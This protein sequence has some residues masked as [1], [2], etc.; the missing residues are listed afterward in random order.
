MLGGVLRRGERGWSGF[1]LQ[2]VNKAFSASVSTACLQRV[3]SV[4]GFA[5][6]CANLHQHTG[7]RRR[8]IMWS[9][10]WSFTLVINDTQSLYLVVFGSQCWCRLKDMIMIHF[11]PSKYHVSSPCL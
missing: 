7:N 4:W 10:H 5:E 2:A 11:L 3:C 1:K 6:F 8:Q 9:V